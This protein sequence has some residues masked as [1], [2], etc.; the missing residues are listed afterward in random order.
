MEQF[1]PKL[2]AAFA[3]R[4]RL[5][6]NLRRGTVVYCCLEIV[7]ADVTVRHCISQFD[8]RYNVRGHSASKVHLDPVVPVLII[9]VLH[10]EPTDEA[11]S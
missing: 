7:A 10:I 2:T 9:A 5:E 8:T 1:G 3:G 11:S 6:W 4:V